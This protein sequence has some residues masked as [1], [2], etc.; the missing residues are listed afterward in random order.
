MIHI[1]EEEKLAGICDGELK[2]VATQQGAHKDVP[3][4]LTHHQQ[5]RQTPQFQE[6]LLVVLEGKGLR[7]ELHMLCR[8]RTVPSNMDHDA[9]NPKVEKE[10]LLTH[11]VLQDQ[12]GH[13][14]LGVIGVCRVAQQHSQGGVLALQ[15]L[16]LS[17]LQRVG[18]THVL[19]KVRAVDIG[20][21]RGG[22]Q[23]HGYTRVL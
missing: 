21:Q 14:A 1:L 19:G 10:V 7:S 23:G 16:E 20:R 8:V 13:G 9:E 2:L 5:A 11:H 4:P 12:R 6:N 22:K 17:D 18:F 3:C 15:L